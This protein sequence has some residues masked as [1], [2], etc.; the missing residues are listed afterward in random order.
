MLLIYPPLFYNLFWIVITSVARLNVNDVAKK[1]IFRILTTFQMPKKKENSES[2]TN[3][4]REFYLHC[5]GH[6]ELYLITLSVGFRLLS[7]ISAF[8]G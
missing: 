2:E 6:T 4:V 3:L 7:L 8:S 1:S 5:Y